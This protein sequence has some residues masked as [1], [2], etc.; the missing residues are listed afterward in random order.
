MTVRSGINPSPE[1]APVRDEDLAPPDRGFGKLWRKAYWVELAA[2][3]VT[4]EDL[5]ADWKSHFDQFWPQGNRLHSD[6]RTLRP[7]DL[8]EM[9]VAL[10]L[11]GSMASGVALLFSRPDSFALLTPRG[12]MFSGWVAFSAHT[13]G[14]N[15]EVRID[16]LMRASDPLFEIGMAAFGHRREDDFWD[17]TLH[18]LALHW[19]QDLQ[20]MKEAVVVD[21]TRLWRNAGNVWHNAAIRAAFGRGASPVRAIL[22]RRR[23]R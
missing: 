3:K 12:H 9:D 21:D 23:Q 10:P 15:R 19:G 1:S 22:K 13:R 5:I 2:L 16:I 17:A 18:N 11:G 14:S 7:D 8:T 6:I 20:P 4:P